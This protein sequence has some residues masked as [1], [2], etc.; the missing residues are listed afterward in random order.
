MYAIRP[1]LS[2][3]K[4][5]PRLLLQVQPNAKDTN[6]LKMKALVTT[7]L[8]IENYRASFRQSQFV[9]IVEIIIVIIQSENVQ[10]LT[11]FL[12]NCLK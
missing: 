5:E 11:S 8:Y 4:A 2:F 10:I 7:C 3:D 12:D 9:R 6:T 1:G